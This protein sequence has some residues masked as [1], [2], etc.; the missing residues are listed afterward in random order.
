MHTV[1]G[2]V[3][4][5]FSMLNPAASPFDGSQGETNYRIEVELNGRWRGGFP[6]LADAGR[7]GTSAQVCLEFA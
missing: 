6:T 4:A 3:K 2:D 1:A 7:T 5:I